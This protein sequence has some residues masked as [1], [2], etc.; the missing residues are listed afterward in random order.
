MSYDESPES[1]KPDLE[2]LT[3]ITL[4]KQTVFELADDRTCFVITPDHL[5]SYNVMD[6]PSYDMRILSLLGEYDAFVKLV[7]DENRIEAQTRTTMG[8]AALFAGHMVVRTGTEHALEWWQV[9]DMD[10]MQRRPAQVMP[11]KPIVDGLRDN[12]DEVYDPKHADFS[13][14]V[15]ELYHT[16]VQM[17]DNMRLSLEDQLIVGHAARLLI[18]ANER[19]E[20]PFT[21]PRGKEPDYN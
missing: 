8:Y 11:L 18:E 19:G 6:K 13:H 15:L 5:K 12:L 9:V 16:R 1:R 14:H 3:G 17:P 7:G 21:P 10:T 2:E 4:P 20:F